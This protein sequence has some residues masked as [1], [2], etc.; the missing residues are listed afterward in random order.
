MRLRAAQLAFHLHTIELGALAVNWGKRLAAIMVV[1]TP[2][3]AHVIG[4]LARHMGTVRVEL[5]QGLVELVHVRLNVAQAPFQHELRDVGH[6]LLSELNAVPAA[7]V[8]DRDHFRF[9]GCVQVLDPIGAAHREVEE[10]PG[11]QILF[12]LLF[13]PPEKMRKHVQ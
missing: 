5:A 13:R 12:H 7:H 3:T 1:F 2:G 8:E 10:I 6:E 9:V 11:L 4:S